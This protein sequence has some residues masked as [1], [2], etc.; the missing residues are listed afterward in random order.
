MFPNGAVPRGRPGCFTR[1]RAGW[2]LRPGHADGSCQGPDHLQDIGELGREI[3]SGSFLRLASLFGELG[4]ERR[5]L[6]RVIQYTRD[7]VMPTAPA[8]G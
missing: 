8:I 4:Q 6:T 7:R 5:L 2:K 1:D 3:F